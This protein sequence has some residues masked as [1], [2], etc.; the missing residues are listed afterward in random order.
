MRFRTSTAAAAT[1]A[2]SDPA[3]ATA[4]INPTPAATFR[5]S[6]YPT[7]PIR[8]GDRH[9]SVKKQSMAARYSAAAAASVEA[10]LLQAL[11][12]GTVTGGCGGGW[13]GVG[14]YAAC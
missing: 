12:A 14:V 10:L 6:V 5:D 9:P 2:S 8:G 13:V 3:P 4:P 11:R 1:P 7:Q